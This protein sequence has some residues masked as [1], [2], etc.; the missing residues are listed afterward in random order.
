MPVLPLPLVFALFLCVIFLQAVLRDE[1]AKWLRVLL[2]LCA[3]HNVLIALVHH[4]GFTD[5]R[6]ILPIT[7]ATIPAFVWVAFKSTA[8]RVFK[9]E[10]LV[11]IAPPFIA[12]LCVLSQPAFLDIL[13]PAIFLGYGGALF[14]ALSGGEDQLHRVRLQHGR[15]PLFIW[16]GIAAVLIVSALSDIAIAADHIFRDGSAQPLIISF[17]GSLSVLAIGALAMA[18]PIAEVVEPAEPVV[19]PL[20]Q[21]ADA[22]LLSRLNVLVSDNALFLNPDLTLSMLSR[23]LSVPV[24]R[25]SAAIN[26]ETGENVSRYINAFRINHAAQLLTSGKTVTEAMFES[27]FNTKSNFNREF[28]RVKNCTPSEWRMQGKE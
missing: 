24:K 25:L 10:D 6:A 11:H 21:I 12:V 26:R 5:L 4:Y 15:T 19:D 22:A 9:I 3:V 18:K 13:V 8:I 27:G 20:D 23:R 28:L 16:R 17:I 1:G 14:F 7:A 2:L